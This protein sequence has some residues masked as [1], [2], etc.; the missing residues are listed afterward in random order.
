LSG[1][2]GG[3]RV[4][5]GGWRV[6][7]GEWR[8]EDG[9]EECGRIGVDGFM[10]PETELFLGTEKRCLKLNVENM[11]TRQVVCGGVVGGSWPFDSQH[12]PKSFR[13]SFKKP[14]SIIQAR[15]E[16]EWRQTRRYAATRP[17][18]SHRFVHR[19]WRRE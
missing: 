10:P 18:S 4:E 8:V 5:G 2:G 13:N 16:F 14:N 1:V 19:A 6:E 7:G 17:T 11:D 9:G 3:L 12:L 15:P